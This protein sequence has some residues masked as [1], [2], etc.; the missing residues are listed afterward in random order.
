MILSTLLKLKLSKNKNISDHS[1]YD[2][3]KWKKEI[4]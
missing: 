1:D 2:K 4:V 3:E